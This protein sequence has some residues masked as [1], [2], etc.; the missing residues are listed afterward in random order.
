MA[1]TVLTRYLAT[2]VETLEADYGVQAPQLYALAGIQPLSSDR[3]DE[4]VADALWTAAEKL[5]DNQLGLKVG[6]R[7]R[8]GTYST[9]GHLLVTTNTVGESLKA[10]C[11]L[12]FY[13]GAAGRLRM[14]TSA[15]ECRV[16]YEPLKDDWGAADVRSEA[17]LLPIVRFARWAS[18]GVVPKSV[19]LVRPCPENP[20]KFEKAFAAPMVFNAPRHEIIWAACDLDRPMT[21]ANPA[22]NEMLRQHVEAEIPSYDSAAANVRVRLAHMVAEGAGGVSVAE[23][24]RAL[25]VSTRSLQRMLELEG[26]NFRSIMN[27][28]RSREAESLLKDTTLSVAQ[29]AYR[30]GYS[31][32][33]AFVRAFN[34]WQGQSPAQWRKW[35]LSKKV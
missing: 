24:A 32:A 9:L 2:L 20:E 25:H 14:E 26:T 1:E 17:V 19:H 4:G 23:A 16:F 12:A 3:S 10:A 28:I 30:L 18:P 27:E 7:V 11:E 6:A 13:V 31:E 21:D 22:L 8:Y 34:R 5:A 29:I 33:A 35:N 15:H